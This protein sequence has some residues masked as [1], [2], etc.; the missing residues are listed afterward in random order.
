MML[1]ATDYPSN[2]ASSCVHWTTLSK[3]DQTTFC[4]L[5][6]R[7]IKP[8]SAHF[9]QDWSNH[10][11]LSHAFPSS[12]HS[13]DISNAASEAFL[14]GKMEC[15]VLFPSKGKNAWMTWSELTCA[16]RSKTHRHNRTNNRKQHCAFLTQTLSRPSGMLASHNPSCNRGI[17]G[18]CMVQKLS[19]EQNK[20]M[21]I[22]VW[23]KTLNH[24]VKQNDYP[25]HAAA[26]AGRVNNNNKKAVTHPQQ[27]RPELPM[28]T[29]TWHASR[30]YT[31]Y[32]NSTRGTSSGLCCHVS[33][34][35]CGGRR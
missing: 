20:P 15:E 23:R 9:V 33:Q 32:M 28:V 24:W 34:S 18:P 11:P 14:A 30:F 35:L 6:P 31:R 10:N 1:S 4:P 22:S 13:S 8:Q 5:C 7:L 2:L 3:T 16:D 29:L 26:C 12:C 25:D 21:S 27:L 17:T 19:R